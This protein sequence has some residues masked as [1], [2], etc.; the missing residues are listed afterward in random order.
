MCMS[1]SMIVQERMRS[2]VVDYL[3]PAALQFWVIDAKLL[4]S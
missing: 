3:Y 2:R 4:A 1:S